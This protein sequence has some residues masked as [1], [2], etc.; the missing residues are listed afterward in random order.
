[1]AAFMSIDIF[2]ISEEVF[3]AAQEIMQKN[4]PRPV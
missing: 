2:I 4:P 3:Y 1:M